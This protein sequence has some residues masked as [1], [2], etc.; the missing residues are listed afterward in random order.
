MRYWP[1]SQENIFE[2][3]LEDQ[4]L[5]SHALLVTDL[6]TDFGIYIDSA[7]I[8]YV[9]FNETTNTCVVVCGVRDY[10]DITDAKVR[11]RVYV[12]FLADTTIYNT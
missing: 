8:W 11:A 3:T 4:S 10:Q 6:Y 12:K 7:G 1:A 5:V 2:A 9:N